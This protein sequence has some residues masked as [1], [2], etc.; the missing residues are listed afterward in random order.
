MM[1]A[2]PSFA[3]RIR[4]RTASVA[5]SRGNAPVVIV[6]MTAREARFYSLHL[7]VENKTYPGVAPSALRVRFP[8][9]ARGVP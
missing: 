7:A 3:T 1:S 4:P 5:N 9:P 6:R 2:A 8:A